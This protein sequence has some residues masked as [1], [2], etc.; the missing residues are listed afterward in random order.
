MVHLTPNPNSKIIQ[1]LRQTLN[2]WMGNK[3]K[4]LLAFFQFKSRPSQCESIKD[5]VRMAKCDKKFSFHHRI[6]IMWI[7]MGLSKVTNL[8]KCL[9]LSMRETLCMLSRH[10]S[11]R[12]WQA[13]FWISLYRSKKLISLAASLNALPELAFH[14]IIVGVRK[15]QLNLKRRFRNKRMD[16]RPKKKSVRKKKMRKYNQEWT[17]I[18]IDFSL[19][20]SL[21]QLLHKSLTHLKVSGSKWWIRTC[22]YNNS[23]YLYSNSK[24][25]S[26]KSLQKMN[27]V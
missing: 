7:R 15:L 6:I 27:T 24:F 19:K 23:F 8:N 3:K 21:K 5:R 1:K 14:P 10:R 4:S 16:K 20:H 9:C 17:L 2:K 13:F 22:K 25:Y 11:S 26:R 18:K 12:V